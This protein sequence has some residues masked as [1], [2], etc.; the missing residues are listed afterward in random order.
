VNTQKIEE[1]ARAEMAGRRDP[2]LREPGWILY[3]GRRTGKIAV[4]LAQR[5]N[6]DANP[7]VLYVAGLFHDVGKN[8]NPHN[9]VGAA[10]A[11]ELLQELATP[12]EIDKIGEIIRH[13]NQRMKSDGFSDAVKLVQD[14]DLIDHAGLI[15]IWMA[16]Y[17]NGTHGE[18]IEEHIAYME[19]Q[20]YKRFRDFMRAHLN[21][22][23]SHEML[24][25][26]IR[27]SDE[28]FAE[29]RRVYFDGI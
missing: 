23:L 8:G 13:H 9:E 5:L 22:D 10:R 7:D 14:A 17:W 3:H 18:S 1:I 15:D 25:E 16:F 12:A 26:R 11:R 24:E 4:H 2:E 6:L 27:L 28:F 29:F 21:F 20:E 19:G